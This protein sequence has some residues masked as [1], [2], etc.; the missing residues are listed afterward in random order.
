MKRS[1]IYGIF[2]SLLFVPLLGLTGLNV[3][4]AHWHFDGSIDGYV[5]IAG[6]VFNALFSFF[7]SVRY[8]VY[9]R[10]TYSGCSRVRGTREIYD[11]LLE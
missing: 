6:L 5:V 9:F 11:R 2:S 10:Q 4:L 3:L 1:F 8:I 7:S